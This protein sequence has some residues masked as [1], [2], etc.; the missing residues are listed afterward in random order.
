MLVEECG[1]RTPLPGPLPTRASRGEGEASDAAKRDSIARVVHPADSSVS[2]A[3]SSNFQKPSHE[4]TAHLLHLQR[5]P[6]DRRQR[7]APLPGPLPT[8]ASRG[9]GEAPDAAKRDSVARVVHAADSSVFSF[10]PLPLPPL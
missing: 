1:K 10:V 7:A 6:W 4:A 8:R 3:P 9:E 2:E 5:G